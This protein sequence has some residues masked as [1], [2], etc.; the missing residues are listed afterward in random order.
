MAIAGGT[1]PSIKLHIKDGAL[2]HGSIMNRPKHMLDSLDVA[3]MKI[4]SGDVAHIALYA[5][6]LATL[7]LSIKYKTG[8]SD[9]FPA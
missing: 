6:N 2:I 7:L 1:S 3:E 8:L 9:A 4:L 5:D